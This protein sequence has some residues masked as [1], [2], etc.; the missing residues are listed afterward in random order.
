M[1]RRDRE[2]FAHINNNIVE[3]NRAMSYRV[4]WCNRYLLLQSILLA[5]ILWRI[6]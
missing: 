3:L 6:W 5:L 1:E 4:G 2:L